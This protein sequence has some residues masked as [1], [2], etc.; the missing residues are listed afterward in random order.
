M[1]KRLDLVG[2]KYGQLTVVE[3]YDVQ[4]GM[5][6]WRCVCDCGNDTIAYGRHLLSGNTQSCGCLGKERRRK[7][8][9]K[10]NLSHSRIYRIW[11]DMKDRCY[12]ANSR[13]YKWYGGKG[14]TV[15]DDWLDVKHFAS[16]AM[17][18]G[19]NDLMTIDRIDSSKGYEPDNC[20]W[21]TRGENARLMCEAIA[22]NYWAKDL[23]AGKL[24][25]FRIVKD[26]AEEHGFNPRIITA[27]YRGEHS[28]IDGWEFGITA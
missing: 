3:F 24:Y 7:A 12:N 1:P 2:N 14:V 11:A 8:V 18:N 23:N 9:E 26:F 10:H 21:V 19:Y 22:K 27:I 13:S 25:E 17:Q 4:H 6:R 5:S 16:W 28:P 20:R 15:C